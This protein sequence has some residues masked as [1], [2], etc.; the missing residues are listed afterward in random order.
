MNVAEI[1]T[2]PRAETFKITLGAVEYQITQRFSTPMNAWVI[3][4]D[5]SDGTPKVHGIMMV[6]GVDLLSQFKHLG[7]DGQLIVQSDNAPDLVP[8][9]TTLGSTGHF[10]FIAP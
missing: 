5:V 2:A 4:I 7:I 9:F 1:P 10:Y 8:D 6:T 3:D